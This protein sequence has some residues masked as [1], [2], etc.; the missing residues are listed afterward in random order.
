MRKSL[1]RFYQRGGWG[2][3][4]V[5]RLGLDFGELNEW[6]AWRV[7]TANKF[8]CGPCG[9]NNGWHGGGDWR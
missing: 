5:M 4:T 6:T 1:R 2:R 8:R 9:A 7:F 3:A